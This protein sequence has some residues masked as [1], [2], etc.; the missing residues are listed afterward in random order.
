MTQPALIEAIADP[1]AA[2]AAL[3]PSR[4]RL[5]AA[6]VEPASAADLAT[7]VGMSR[8]L[9]NHHLRTLE[10]H[11]LI[12][13]VE[14][15]RKGNV[16]E[17]VLRATAASWVVSPDALGAAA[18]DPAADGDRLSAA[19]LLAISARMVAEVG[20]LVR[21]ASTSRKRLATLALDVEV[22]F[23]SPADRAV[24][25]EELAAAVTALVSRHH[26]DHGRLHRL[27]L[28]VHP[29]PEEAP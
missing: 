25:A 26:A 1:G 3:E 16:L 12:A 4:A 22:R 6:L 19:Y 14:E 9:V 24:F 15:R 10:R 17:R 5:L 21:G 29:L 23:A 13:L 27:V 11:G 18:P 8:Q 20:R 7:R 2:V 28:G